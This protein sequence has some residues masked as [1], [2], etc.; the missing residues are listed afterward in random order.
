METSLNKMRQTLS[1]CCVVRS[2]MCDIRYI[3]KL[4]ITLIQY[5]MFC[6]FLALLLIFLEFPRV[7]VSYLSIGIFLCLDLGHLVY[8]STFHHLQEKKIRVYF[9]YDS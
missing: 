3:R 1:K 8:K 7:T 4:F 2:I 9:L 6:H 5:V